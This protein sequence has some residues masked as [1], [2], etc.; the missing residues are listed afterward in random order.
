MSAVIEDNTQRGILLV[1]DDDAILQLNCI[2]L[3]R[4]GYQNIFTAADGINALSILEAHASE[5]YVVVLDQMMPHMTGIEIIKHLSNVHRFHVGIILLSGK[6]NAE[7]TS[8]FYK[9]SSEKVQSMDFIAKPCSNDLLLDHVNAVMCA[10]H[11]KRIGHLSLSAEQ[12]FNRIDTIEDK[13]NKLDMLPDIY[14]ELQANSKLHNSFIEEIGKEIIKAVII[15]IFIIAVLYAGIGD[16]IK[17]IIP[18]K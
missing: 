11:K 17:Q 6:A 18:I 8:D 1:D 16:F 7:I 2:I 12:I 4:K 3:R 14:K 10:I 15:A 5:I 13:L 9:S